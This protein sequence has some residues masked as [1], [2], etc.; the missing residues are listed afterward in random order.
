MY[1]SICSLTQHFLGLFFVVL[2][3]FFFQYFSGTRHLVLQGFRSYKISEV[4]L[5]W[6]SNQNERFSVVRDI[7]LMYSILKVV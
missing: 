1:N 6:Y 5:F 7:S 4:C 3:W 2:F